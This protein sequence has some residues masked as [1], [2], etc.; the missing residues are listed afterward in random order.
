MPLSPLVSRDLVIFKVVMIREVQ[1]SS[2]IDFFFL[3]HPL[4][5]VYSIIGYTT[6]EKC[7]GFQ[8]VKHPVP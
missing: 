1:D 6:L 5:L 8:T 2:L 4:K 3:A 7:E